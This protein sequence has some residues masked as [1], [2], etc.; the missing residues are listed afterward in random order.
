[1][2]LVKFFTTQISYWILH[3]KE[4]AM[5]IP[6]TWSRLAIAGCKELQLR[7]LFTLQLI[8]F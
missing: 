2:W 8:G 1:M 5:L 4:Q 3:C 7:Q 6:V